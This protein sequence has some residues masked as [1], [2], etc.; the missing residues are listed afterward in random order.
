MGCVQSKPKS[1]QEPAVE[2]NQNG[3]TEEE[4]TQQTQNQRYTPEPSS[5]PSASHTAS[6]AS[7][8]DISFGLDSGRKYIRALYDYTARTHDDLTFSKG[9]IMEL[10]DES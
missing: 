1:P 3:K 9:D 6:V 10:V 5:A 7:P 4:P 8:N 2:F